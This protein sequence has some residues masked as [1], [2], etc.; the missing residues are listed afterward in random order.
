M[1]ILDVVPL[2]G[3][4]KADPLDIDVGPV[5]EGS[6]NDSLVGL[7]ALVVL[8]PCVPSLA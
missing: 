1:G 5:E 7:S 6:P 3:T 4:S 2:P 8:V